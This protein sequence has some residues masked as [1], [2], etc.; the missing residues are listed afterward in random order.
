MG[1][2]GGT[3]ATLA[4]QQLK[5]LQFCHCNYPCCGGRNDTYLLTCDVYMTRY[6]TDALHARIHSFEKFHVLFGRGH[7]A[8]VTLRT[9]FNI[10]RPI[11]LASAWPLFSLY[12]GLEMGVNNGN[13]IH[14]NVQKK[15][16]VILC[17]TIFSDI[18]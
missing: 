3:Y 17:F 11:P 6:Y 2:G 7:L 13:P 5:I 8:F 12:V 14:I 9:H 18:L 4:I 1:G 10:S 15:N 16:Y